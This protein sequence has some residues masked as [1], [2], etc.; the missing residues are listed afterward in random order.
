MVAFI[1]SNIISGADNSLLPHLILSFWLLTFLLLLLL[2]GNS[3]FF[4]LDRQLFRCWLRQIVP[5]TTR[6]PFRRVP[7]TACTCCTTIRGDRLSL[8][9]KEVDERGETLPD[10][11]SGQRRALLVDDYSLLGEEFKVQ[12]LLNLFERHSILEIT[13]INHDYVWDA[14]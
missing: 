10:A 13:L 7:C 9:V 4:H 1:S 8:L 6:H 3:L 5:V 14:S 11:S 12:P 2:I